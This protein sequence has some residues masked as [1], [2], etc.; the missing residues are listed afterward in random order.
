MYPKNLLNELK[1]ITV[2]RFPNEKKNGWRKIGKIFFKSV[3]QEILNSSALCSKTSLK[4]Y[5]LK[6]T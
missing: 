4:K 1:K 5:K 2:S 3:K 6:V